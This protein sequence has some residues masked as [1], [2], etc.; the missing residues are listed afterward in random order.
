M[1]NAE[2]NHLDA[3]PSLRLAFEQVANV[4]SEQKNSA[5]ALDTKASILLALAT[6]LIGIGFPLGVGQVDR[7]IPCGWLVSLMVTILI[8]LLVY[9][10]VLALSFTGLRFR[11]FITLNDPVEAWKKLAPLQPE[12]FYRGVLLNTARRF[13]ENSDALD[14][15]AKAI[16]CLLPTV[17]LGTISVLLWL[18]FAFSLSLVFGRF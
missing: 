6:A 17:V 9:C 15:K 16:S 18:A 1:A 11:R 5:A 3:R 7:G 10:R 2:R 12:E 13:K 8:P 4:L 14:E